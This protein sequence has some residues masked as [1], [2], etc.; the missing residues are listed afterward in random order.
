MAEQMTNSANSHNTKVEQL[1]NIIK[2]IN[3]YTQQ[4]INE[5]HKQ[6]EQ[7][8]AILRR[9]TED[10][11]NARFENTKIK[12]Q[13]EINKTKKNIENLE[14]QE[15]A[16]EIELN[17]ISQLTDDEKTKLDELNKKIVEQEEQVKNEQRWGGF[18][19]SFD[20]VAFNQME[21]SEAVLQ[22]L[23]KQRAELLNVAEASRINAQINIYQ[24]LNNKIQ[25]RVN[26]LRNMQPTD[27][28]ET[29]IT[30]HTGTLLFL[31]SKI[32]ELQKQKAELNVPDN[33]IR[34]VTKEQQEQIDNEFY[35]ELKE[36]LSRYD[37]G[38][39]SLDEIK[40]LLNPYTTEKS[41][42]EQ[43]PSHSVESQQQTRDDTDIQQQTDNILKQ[44]S[45]TKQ[46]QSQ[47]Q[48]QIQDLQNQIQQLLKENDDLKQQYAADINKINVEHEQHVVGLQNQIQQRQQQIDMFTQQQE[49][50]D[51]REDELGIIAN[52]LEKIRQ[53]V[54]KQ[55]QELS[56][57]Q[58]MLNVEQ[59]K[60]NIKDGDLKEREIALNNLETQLN[61]QQ[62][63]LNQQQIEIQQQLEQLTDTQQTV[64]QQQ[65]IQQQLQQLQE[66]N[67]K[68]Q[69]T[70][71]TQNQT[72]INNDKIIND[73]QNAANQQ[74]IDNARLQQVNQEQ[75][76]R[77]QQ[78]QNKNVDLSGKVK[79]FQERAKR[80]ATATAKQGNQHAI[81]QQQ[82]QKRQT[83]YSQN[84]KKLKEDNAKEIDKLNQQIQNL[85]KEKD[86]IYH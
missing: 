30:T 54:D 17:Q 25:N 67:E 38:K 76:N 20:G 41:D 33:K 15:K 12:K 80:L 75:Q 3:E 51:K 40:S 18:T 57:N 27:A 83:E 48:Q 7:Q 49:D 55:Q 60:L 56:A 2:R 63:Q 72:I 58:Q 23:K 84:I 65:Q 50:F 31:A 34:A 21:K 70:V 29:E 62:N 44:E 1:D 77:I 5:I 8:Q 26:E 68:L 22:D 14:K 73:L 74:Q 71:D 11:D 64:E 52:D 85:Q 24:D 46:Q 10:R 37:N 19:A 39:I 61:Q 42:N 36:F 81:Q 32:S 66:Q 69:Q 86:E 45:E 35:A 43:T 13:R 9:Q 59:E 16:Q 6:L 79:T 28:N 53:D 47:N 78:L 4:Q 82:L